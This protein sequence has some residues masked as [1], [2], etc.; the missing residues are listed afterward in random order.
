MDVIGLNVFRCIQVDGFTCLFLV[1]AECTWI[2]VDLSGFIWFHVYFYGINLTK[3][4]YLYLVAFG[5]TDF[6]DLMELHGYKQIDTDL[7]VFIWI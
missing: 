1:F 4:I 2:Y 7:H 6:Y 5:W 3:W